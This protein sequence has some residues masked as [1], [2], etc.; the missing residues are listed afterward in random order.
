M[1]D[2]SVPELILNADEF[3][4]FQ[5]AW[6]NVSITGFFFIFVYNVRQVP[7]KEFFFSLKYFF[8]HLVVLTY[9][10]QLLVCTS[11]VANLYEGKFLSE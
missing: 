8:L 1:P 7:F 4:Q 10:F 3:K 11:K 2:F 9:S 6:W 5:D